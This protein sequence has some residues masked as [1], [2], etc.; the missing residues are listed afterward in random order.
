LI[1]SGNHICLFRQFSGKM[2]HL[3]TIY[4]IQNTVQSANKLLSGI[5][6][7]RNY[8]MHHVE[9]NKLTLFNNYT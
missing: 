2:Y 4:A 5:M 9:K 1:P 3:A 8:Y 7:I 6:L